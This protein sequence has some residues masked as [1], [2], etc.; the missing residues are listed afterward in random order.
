MGSEWVF[1]QM[2]RLA[3]ERQML[4]QVVVLLE[5]NGLIE[6]ISKPGLLLCGVFIC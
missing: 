4:T 6:T 3:V 1:N 5:M 2:Q